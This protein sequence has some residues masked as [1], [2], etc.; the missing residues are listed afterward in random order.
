LSGASSIK[1]FGKIFG[2]QKDYWIAQGTIVGEE[3]KSKNPLK[4]KRGEGANTH[5]FWVTENLLKDWI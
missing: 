2:S 3:E 1:F 5:I 4:E